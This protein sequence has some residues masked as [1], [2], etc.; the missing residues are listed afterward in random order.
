[1]LRDRVEVHCLLSE[2]EWRSTILVK[3]RVEVHFLLCERY[4]EGGGKRAWTYSSLF[5]TSRD[6]SVLVFCQ[7]ASHY[8]CVVCFRARTY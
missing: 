2:T 1:M 8:T 3:D 4:P 6:L 5:L 7:S